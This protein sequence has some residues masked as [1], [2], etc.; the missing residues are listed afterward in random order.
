MRIIVADDSQE[1]LLLVN[2]LLKQCKLQNPVS[3]VSDSI[4]CIE[5]LKKSAVEGVESLLFL[6]LI[7]PPATGLDVLKYLQTT[8]YRKDCLVVMLSGLRDVKSINTGYQL[9]AK[10]FLLK[11]ISTLDVVQLVNSLQEVAI[12]EREDGYLLHWRERLG[13]E[14]EWV[15]K[16][17]RIQTLAA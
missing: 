1:D 8:D 9:G 14:S 6:D 10:T 15:R 3:L 12:E 11:P 17:G 7:M 13:A 2:R 16:T 4:H 5:E